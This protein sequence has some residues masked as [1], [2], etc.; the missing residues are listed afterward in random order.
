MKQCYLL[1]IKNIAS[2]HG[3][4]EYLNENVWIIW[5]HSGCCIPGFQLWA[6]TF[7]YGTWIEI[8][9]LR[10]RWEL[11]KWRGTHSWNHTPWCRTWRSTSTVI[12]SSFYPTLCCPPMSQATRGQRKISVLTNELPLVMVPSTFGIQ[13][14]DGTYWWGGR[15]KGTFCRKIQKTTYAYLF[16]ILFISLLIF[17]LLYYFDKD[18]FICIC[19][20]VSLKD[21]QYHSNI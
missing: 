17:L 12:F 13:C 6:N 14:G 7:V 18:H 4:H 21:T 3:I 11:G 10:I 15:G 2:Q 1:L 19:Q 5:F 8:C 16:L 20:C 9:F